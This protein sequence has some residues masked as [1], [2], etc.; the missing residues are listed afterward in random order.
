MHVSCVWPFLLR[1]HI[2]V[3]GAQNR[4]PHQRKGRYGNHDPTEPC[5]V[6]V[7]IFPRM[8]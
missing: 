1:Y 3:V 6:T 5:A 7:V 4:G 8:G 2:W